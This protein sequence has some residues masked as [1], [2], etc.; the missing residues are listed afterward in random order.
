[1]GVG[2]GEGELGLRVRSLRFE[3]LGEEVEEEGISRNR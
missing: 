2:G 3:W 1:M